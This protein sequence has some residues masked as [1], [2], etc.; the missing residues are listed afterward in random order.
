VAT[1]LQVPPAVNPDDPFSAK[2]IVT[3]YARI[4]NRDLERGS[5]PLPTD[6]LPFAKPTIK[7]AI[8]TSLL[9]LISTGQL[10][11]E[12][13]EFLETAYVSLADYVPADLVQLMREYARA[14]D[15][16]AADPRLAREKTTGAAWQT[17][18]GGSRLAG[19]IARSMA[20]EAD[21][22]KTEFQQLL[23]CGASGRHETEQSSSGDAAS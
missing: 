20:S 11:E 17:V 5:F 12:L 9:A 18:A 7:T 19:E 10:T 16:L 6:S 21:Q 13:R 23:V 8:E 3:E 15:D 1:G 14:G 2:Q 4:L 22:L